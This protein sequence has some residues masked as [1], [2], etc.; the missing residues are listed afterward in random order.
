MLSSTG[1]GRKAL[2]LCNAGGDETY[3]TLKTERVIVDE[4]HRRTSRA[5][6]DQAAHSNAPELIAVA[7]TGWHE[8]EKH[9][10][11][12]LVGAA[13]DKLAREREASA[14]VVVA[15]PHTTGRH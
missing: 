11:V 3:P 6:I 1:D 7:T 14:I 4:N 13:L 5:R 15:P 8:L 9:R 12:G 2:F 10:F